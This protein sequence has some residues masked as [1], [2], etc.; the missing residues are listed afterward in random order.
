MK[1]KGIKR[2]FTPKSCPLATIEPGQVVDVKEVEWAELKIK[3]AVLEEV[4]EVK[5]VE[6]PA[7]KAPVKRAVK[8]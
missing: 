5:K 8:K 2:T 1:V 7:V 3:Q 4:K 6:K